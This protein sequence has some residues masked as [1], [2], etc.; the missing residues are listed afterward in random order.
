MVQ[1]LVEEKL[2]SVF[3]S[4]EYLVKNRHIT[5]EDWLE[6]LR[7]VNDN[8][9]WKSYIARVE[10][11]NIAVQEQAKLAIQEQGEEKIPLTQR[12]ISILSPQYKALRD[13]CSLMPDSI[14]R[15]QVMSGINRLIKKGVVERQTSFGKDIEP[16]FRLANITA[17]IAAN[18]TANIAQAAD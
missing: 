1:S 5:L 16:N 4:V 7:L 18:I 9:F 13:I 11:Q 12:I 15:N 8:Q 2:R 14:E 10:Q 3:I 17:N 6:A